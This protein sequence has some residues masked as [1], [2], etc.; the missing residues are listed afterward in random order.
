MGNLGLTFYAIEKNENTGNT[1][2]CRLCPNSKKFSMFLTTIF[3]NKLIF[4][5]DNVIINTSYRI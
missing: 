5:Q 2:Q 4:E 1:V 3:R